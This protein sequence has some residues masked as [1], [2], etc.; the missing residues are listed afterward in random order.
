MEI[1]V[2]YNGVDISDKCKAN[3]AIHEMYLRKKS[4][5]LEIQFENKNDQWT[6][7]KPD[8]G[9]TIRVKAQYAD[10]GIMKVSEINWNFDSV[11]LYANAIYKADMVTVMKSWEHV[12]LKQI[13]EEIAAKHSYEVQYF[14]I[15]DRLYGY[16][17][18]SENDYAFLQK[19]L[20]LED[21]SF[22]VYN[23]KIIVYSNEYFADMDAVM[24]LSLNKDMEYKLYDSQ[25]YGSCHVT[26]GTHEGKHIINLDDPVLSQNL[27]VNIESM[28][29]ADRYAKNILI[30]GNRNFDSWIRFNKCYTALMAGSVVMLSTDIQKWNAKILIDH[31]RQD[32]INDKTKIWIGKV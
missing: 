9:D 21:A 17:E 13:I 30:Q 15:T 18:Q 26:N 20:Y 10:T 7:W 12:Y 29:E 1:E 11:T 4:D 28:A 31:V 14:G 22:V 5:F 16:V 2:E 19:R 32:Y 3:K 25:V 24:S 27:N 23:G 6:M 8:L